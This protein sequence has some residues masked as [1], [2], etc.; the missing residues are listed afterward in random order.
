MGLLAHPVPG[1]SLLRCPSESRSINH[2]WAVDTISYFLTF[3][4]TAYMPGLC[5]GSKQKKY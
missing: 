3:F 1:P 5:M 4:K 2:R